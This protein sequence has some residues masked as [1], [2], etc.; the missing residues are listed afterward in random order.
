MFAVERVTAADVVL[1][2]P[3]SVTNEGPL[4]LEADK[5]HGSI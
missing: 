1:T 4:A 2:R 3:W 5:R